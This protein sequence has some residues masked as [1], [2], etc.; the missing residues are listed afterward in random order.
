MCGRYSLTTP[1]E[2]VA[3]VFDLEE[4]PELAP[5]Y[6]IAPSQEV[7]VVR[8]SGPE[9]RRQLDLLRWGLIP[10]WA[11]DKALGNRMINA[12]AETLADRPA[13]RWSF[14]KRRCLLV[15]DGFFEWKRIN[16]R[17]QPHYIRLRDR[18]PFG[19]A[20]LWDRWPDP[21]GPAIESC[22]VVTTQPNEL[23]AGIHDRM[24]VIVAPDSFGRW[25]DPAVRD[26]KLLQ[27]LLQ[28]YPA[29]ELE[30]YAVSMAVNDP[31][32]DGPQCVAAL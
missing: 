11:E 5:R 14:R 16:G 21:D 4:V 10:F 25:L 26:P 24:P 20:G 27:N 22:T 30:A 29:G 19:L 15:A 2:F 12:R 1:G 7:A 17:K 32:T 31:G 9:G 6:N 8:A 13:F 18:R 23:L 3:E 28:P